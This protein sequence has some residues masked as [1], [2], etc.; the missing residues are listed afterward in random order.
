ML[1]NLLES[2]TWAVIVATGLAGLVVGYLVRH[3]LGSRRIRTAESRARRIEEE[4]ETR[5]K[6]LLLEAQEA[7]LQI[8]REAEEEIERRRA[9][10]QRQESRLQS[11]RESLDKKIES[12]EKRQSRLAKRQARLKRITREVEGLRAE[13]IEALERLSSLS[14]D[15]AKELL[16]QRV[17]EESR[18]D[19]AR[20]LREV[21]QQLKEDADRLAQKVISVAVQRA[22]SEHVAEST[23]ATVP[24]PSDD[25]KGR[26]IGKQGR[27]IRAMEAAL[28]VDLIVDD[29]PEAVTISCFDP[30]RRETARLA[31][32]KLILDGRIHPARIEELVA[33]TKEEMQATLMEEG[34]RALYELGLPRLP[35]EI[36]QLLGRLKYRTSYGQNQLSHAMETARIAATLAAELGANVEWVKEGALLHDLGKAVSH[37]TE[38]PH[39][40]IGAEIVRRHRRPEA[41]VNAIESHH[42]EVDQRFVESVIVE[43]ADAISGARPGA[44]RESL[45]HYLKRLR[46]LEEVA[47]SFDGVKT[48]YAIQAGREVR[49]IV[50]PEEVDD[51]AAIHLSKDVARKI[52]ESLEYP[53]QVKVMVIRETRAVDHA[54]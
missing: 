21:E 52:E 23:V 37:E 31:L 27:N 36:V 17:E 1:G 13:Q 40:L 16:L 15:Q 42:H 9:A 34:E 35:D 32:T 19:M 39:A 38:G 54:K 49:I 51:L 46:A 43:S 3:Y 18:Q 28:G 45:E 4:I 33:K 7:A 41:V 48:A 50:K 20:V 44:R 29:T 26:I 30:V 12:I 53:G 25:M 24:L 11:R 2:G 10:S 8:R 6:E 47:T 14:T 5:Q 22:A